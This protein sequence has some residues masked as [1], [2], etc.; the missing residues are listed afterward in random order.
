M[1]AEY[2][3]I[4]PGSLSLHVSGDGGISAARVYA[5]SALTLIEHARHFHRDCYF[6]LRLELFQDLFGVIAR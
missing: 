6:A 2:V 5:C 3:K 4:D 1:A